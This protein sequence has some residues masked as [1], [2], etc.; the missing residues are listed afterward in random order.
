MTQ[1]G[2]ST[3]SMQRL[4]MIIAHGDTESFSDLQ[5]YKPIFVIKWHLI[6]RLP[7]QAENTKEQLLK[8]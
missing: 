3:T 6:L 8:T 2:A 4:E 7:H 1:L 5:P